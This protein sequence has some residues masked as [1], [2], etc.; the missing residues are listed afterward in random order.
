LA[1]VDDGCRRNGGPDC[2]GEWW[3]TRHATTQRERTAELFPREAEAVAVASLA[4]IGSRS[5]SSLIERYQ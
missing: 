3:Q 5:R 1:V 2:G 4:I